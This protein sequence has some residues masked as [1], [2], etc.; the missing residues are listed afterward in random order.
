ML[1]PET[2]TIRESVLEIRYTPNS[3]ILDYRGTWAE[4][5]SS[6]MVLSEWRI[7]QNRID[8]FDKEETRRG[9]VSFKNAGIVIRNA[10]T[11]DYF[12]DQANKLLRFLFEQKPFGNPLWLG[13]IGVRTRFATAYEG[14]FNS[15]LGR[16]KDRFL[17]ISPEALNTWGAEIID[18]GGPV[19]FRTSQG[20]LNSMSGPMRKEELKRF[21]DFEDNLPEVALYFDLDYWKEPKSLIEGREAMRIVKLFAEESWDTHERLRTLILA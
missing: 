18:I 9:F 2:H 20:Y 10:P 21:F 11:R 17:N 12:P 6:L 7:S 14:D 5:V 1:T 3:K 13:R 16:Y 15:L 4:L 8:V 19:N